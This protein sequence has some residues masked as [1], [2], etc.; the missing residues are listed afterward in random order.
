MRTVFWQA[1]VLINRKGAEKEKL[2][3]GDSILHS[4]NKEKMKVK[5]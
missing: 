5:E 2:V 1:W 3:L 4:G